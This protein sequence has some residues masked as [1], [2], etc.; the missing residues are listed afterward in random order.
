[1]ASLTIRN[2]EEA[3]KTRLRVRAA[4]NG[5]SMEEDARAI[6][7]TALGHAAGEQ[8]NLATSIH[9]RFVGLGDAEFPAVPREPMRDPPSFEE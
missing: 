1:M 3:V 7:R 8:A 2:V 9:A 4:T 6:L 5:R